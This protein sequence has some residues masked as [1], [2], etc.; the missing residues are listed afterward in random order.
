MTL[1]KVKLSKA[2]FLT[3]DYFLFCTV[4][5][6]KPVYWKHNCNVGVFTG[7]IIL[8]RRMFLQ[9]PY[10]QLRSITNLSHSLLFPCFLVPF[11]IVPLFSCPN[12]YC[13]LVFLSHSLLFPC[14][15]VPIFIVPLFSCPILYCSLVF[16]LLFPCFSVFV[17]L[18]ALLCRASALLLYCFITLHYITSCCKH[19]S[20]YTWSYNHLYIHAFMW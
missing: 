5:L 19:N 1:V 3:I 9:D 20:Y 8:L 12:L 2:E 6:A 7:P 16:S 18:F 13:S 4:K 17:C 10:S 11:F 15:L 14:F